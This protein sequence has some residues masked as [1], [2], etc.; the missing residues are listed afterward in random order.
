M[1][2]NGPAACSKVALVVAIGRRSDRMVWQAPRN[3]DMFRAAREVIRN[4]GRSLCICTLLGGH[5]RSEGPQAI[6]RVLVIHPPCPHISERALN[7][8][9]GLTFH[10]NMVITMRRTERQ[11]IG[12]AD[13][14]HSSFCAAH[15]V[16][17]RSRKRSRK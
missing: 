11:R 17:P 10:A 15:I 13:T 6:L 2:G 12:D 4:K 1:G 3:R 7:G 5:D 14:V 9:E 16:A 8:P